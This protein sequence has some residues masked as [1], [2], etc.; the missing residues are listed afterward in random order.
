M[1]K[2][3]LILRKFRNSDLKELMS[4]FVNDEILRNTNFP[5]KAKDIVK[6]DE[7]KLLKNIIKNYRLKKPDEY[8]L[9]IIVNKEL[10]GAVGLHKIDYINNSSETGYWIAE[11]YWNNGYATLALK[12]F[13]DIVFKK[14][15]F[16]RIYAYANDY[17]IG[18]QKV[19]E[20]SGFKLEC[21]R[22]KSVKK[23]NKYI[24]DK[25]YALVRK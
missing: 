19:L 20:K 3:E 1:A 18:S 7:I 4:K 5:K 13:L 24:D 8:N 10:V 23:G 6:S 25:Q 21:I 9:A 17:N 2:E 11:P 12:K 16:V 22:K 14:F 15:K